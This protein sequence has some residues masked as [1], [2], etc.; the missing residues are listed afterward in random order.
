MDRIGQ[1]RLVLVIV[2][3]GMFFG[4]IGPEIRELDSW[5]QTTTPDFIGFV[6]IQVGVVVG[7]WLAGQL[8]PGGKAARAVSSMLER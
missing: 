6:L 8:T 1:G 7:A 4:L 5:Q 2:G 3:A